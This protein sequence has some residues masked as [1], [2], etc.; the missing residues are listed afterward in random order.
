[1]EV[2]MRWLPLFA[3]ASFA[4]SGEPE[5]TTASVECEGE[6]SVFEPGMEMRSDQGNFYLTLLSADP[7]PPD[8]GDND[9]IVRLETES[10]STVNGGVVVVEPWMPLH[11]HG[12]NPPNYPGRETGNGEYT[13][14]T[15][16]LIMPG[17]WE[18]QFL[19]T[20]SMMNDTAT[21]SFCVEG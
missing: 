3:V 11:G 7:D 18:F 5:D 6:Y 19:M 21:V 9:W 4:C 8:E 17:V 14:P 1:M 12:V 20:E 16:D 13:I 2:W 10:R 15:F